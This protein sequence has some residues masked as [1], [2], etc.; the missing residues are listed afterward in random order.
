MAACGKRKRRVS[1]KFCVAGGPGN[2]SCTN[3]SS[4]TDI[5]MHM[6]PSHEVTRRKWTKF[7]QRHRPSFRPTKSSVLCSVHFTQDCYARRID[8]L[9]S[10][11]QA[12]LSNIA[13]TRRLNKGAVPTIDTAITPSP[14]SNLS[15]RDKKKVRLYHVFAS[16]ICVWCSIGIVRL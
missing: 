2:V 13:S 7:V 5:S 4:V 1:G 15:R 6:F 16:T 3:N 8:L 14:N 10:E 11:S 12:D 9:G